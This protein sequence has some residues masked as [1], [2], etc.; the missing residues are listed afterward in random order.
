MVLAGAPIKDMQTQLEK[1]RTEAAECARVAQSA[2]EASKR[3]LFG[4]LAQHHAVLAAE[5]EKAIHGTT[6]L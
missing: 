2:T 5:V 3:E 1:L 6:K 4:K